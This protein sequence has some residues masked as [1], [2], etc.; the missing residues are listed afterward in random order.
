MLDNR[1]LQS[2]NNST[3]PVDAD[4]HNFLLPW[5]PAFRLF[6]SKDIRMAADNISPLLMVNGIKSQFCLN[7]LHVQAFSDTSDNTIPDGADRRIYYLI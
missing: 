6:P 5:T 1:A 3:K 7:W 4:S 2:M